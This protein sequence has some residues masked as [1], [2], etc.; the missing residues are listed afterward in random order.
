MAKK[1][2]KEYT[3]EEALDIAIKTLTPYWF[4]SPPL[5]YGAELEGKVFPQPIDPAITKG[6]WILIFSSPTGFSFYRSHPLFLEWEKRFGPL[7]IQLAFCFLGE[8]SF[9]TE[10]RA[11]EYWLKHRN[12]KTIAICD[13]DGMLL[14]A[15]GGEPLPRM[16]ILNN[17]EVIHNSGGDKWLENAEVELQKILRKTS[18]GLPFWMP[19]T[20]PFAS[21]VETV[22]L[23]FFANSKDNGYAGMQWTGN[24]KSDENRMYTLDPKSEITFEP[25]GNMIHFIAQSLGEN[26]TPT[27]VIFNCAGASF[28]EHFAGSDLVLDDEGHSSVILTEPRAY[29]ILQNLS[30]HHKKITL[31]FP[32]ARV[33]PV[34]V[35]GLSMGKMPPVERPKEIG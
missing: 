18:P 19:Y 16:V 3:A 1:K 30:Q 33:T 25:T 4:K 34:A 22:R 14:K 8:H 15:F 20:E 26:F 7:G 17:G 11:A 23:R 24:W 32:N 31:R 27:R 35:Y 12:I 13:Y 2:D 28:S 6:V 5:I 29:F 21:L 9:V 10:H